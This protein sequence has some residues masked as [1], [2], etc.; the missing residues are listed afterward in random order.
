M[1]TELCNTSEWDWA[2]VSCCAVRP[3]GKGGLKNHKPDVPK[4]HT[5]V[6][7]F[8]FTDELC[9]CLHLYLGVLNIW[10]AIQLHFYNSF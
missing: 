3:K 2:L 5:A 1:G 8:E 4:L 7:R 6:F 10:K 9:S